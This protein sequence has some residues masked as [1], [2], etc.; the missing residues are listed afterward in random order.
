M[1]NTLWISVNFSFTY[2]GASVWSFHPV[3]L[4]QKHPTWKILLLLVWSRDNVY[5]APSL[6]TNGP[7]EDAIMLKL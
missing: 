6:S 3:K 4:A 7:V 5:D 1:F 2:K